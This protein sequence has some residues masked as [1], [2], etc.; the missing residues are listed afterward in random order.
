MEYLNFDVFH[1]DVSPRGEPV[2]ACTYPRS[3]I[4]GRSHGLF[5]GYDTREYA[6]GKLYTF[7]HQP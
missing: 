6:A 1:S 2:D 4:V 7:I 3:G 5:A